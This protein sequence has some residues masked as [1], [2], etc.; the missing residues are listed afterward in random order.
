M[1]HVT[2]VCNYISL[3]VYETIIKYLL[4]NLSRR[5]NQHFKLRINV[6]ARE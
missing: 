6:R 3:A 5:L 2:I 1:T 4:K